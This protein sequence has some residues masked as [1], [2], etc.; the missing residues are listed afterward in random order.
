MDD[1]NP[2]VQPQ[3]VQ[4]LECSGNFVDAGFG[5]LSAADWAGVPIQQVLDMI[6]IDP[7][8][9]R[10]LISG[11]DHTSGNGSVPGAAWIFTFEQLQQAGAFLATEMNGVPLPLDHGFP[12]RLLIPGWFGCCNIKW[13]NEIILVDESEP[14]T[15]QM[16]EFASRTLQPGT[17]ALAAD[18]IPA[19][20]DQTAVPVLVEKWLHEG[21]LVYRIKGVMWGGYELTDKLVIQFDDGPWEPVTVCPQQSSNATWTLWEHIWRPPAAGEYLMTMHIDDPNVPQRR[22]DSGRYHRHVI[23]DEV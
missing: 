1:L 4:L 19:T 20:I 10:V 5:L 15:G 6:D 16:Q 2:L 22:L 3:G 14:A 9:T 13:V 21:Q 11:A 12:V 17:P 23:I 18:Y 7:A 8:A